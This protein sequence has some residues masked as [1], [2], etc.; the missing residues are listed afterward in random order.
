[1]SPHCP[2]C[3]HAGTKE[4]SKEFRRQNK[5]P[6]K[7]RKVD[8]IMKRL[9]AILPAGGKIRIARYVTRHQANHLSPF[10]FLLFA[11]SALAFG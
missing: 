5:F 10:M 1:L 11:I 8:R 6:R 2:L 9:K 3:C 4:N 7:Q